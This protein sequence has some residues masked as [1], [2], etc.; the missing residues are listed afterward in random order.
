M[1][2]H[3]THLKTLTHETHL[4]TNGQRTRAVKGVSAPSRGPLHTHVT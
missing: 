2:T 1:V 3:E 4:K